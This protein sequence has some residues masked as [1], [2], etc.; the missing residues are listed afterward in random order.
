MAT[1]RETTSKVARI[2]A[3]PW[4][5]VVIAAM[6]LAGFAALAPSL[7]PAA[8]AKEKTVKETVKED[9]KQDGGVY[10]WSES[11]DYGCMFP[12]GD[13]VECNELLTDLAGPVAC[14]WTVEG[15][16]EPKVIDEPAP[17]P[18]RVNRAPADE[19]LV[20]EPAPTATPVTRQPAATSGDTLV[21]VDERSR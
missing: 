9:C 20:H 17:A 7:G 6:L 4:R 15:E 8:S 10:W 16:A 18:T 1:M 2:A 11:G 3:A 14:V 12:N 5:V 19:K 21:V 13:E